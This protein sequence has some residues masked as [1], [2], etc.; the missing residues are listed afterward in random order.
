MA[1]LMKIYL[2]KKCI[3]NVLAKYKTIKNSHNNNNNPTNR[4]L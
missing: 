1:L 4:V 2:Q 3:M